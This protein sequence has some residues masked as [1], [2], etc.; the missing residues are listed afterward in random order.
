[1]IPLMARRAPSD[2]VR[3]MEKRMKERIQSVCQ[4]HLDASGQF[5]WPDSKVERDELASRLLGACIVAGMDSSIEKALSDLPPSLSSE[6]RSKFEQLLFEA[7]KGVVFSILVK[8]D[9]FPQAN[10]DLVLSDLETQKNLASVTEGDIF[11]LHDRL[12]S[13]LEEFSEYA[14]KFGAGRTRG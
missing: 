1:M 14:K 12:W 11:D 6:Q 8:L 4:E 9:Q 5:Q 7:V 3:P 13:W 2:K 10:L